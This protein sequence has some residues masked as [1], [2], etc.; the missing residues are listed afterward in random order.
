MN[1]SY[2]EQIKSGNTELLEKGNLHVISNIFAPDYIVYSG[3]KK[4]SG[5]EFIKRWT[6]QLR[7]A[8]PDVRIIKVEFHIQ[9]ENMIVWQRT[10]LG[11]HKSTIMG[12]RPSGQKI[13]WVEMVISRFTG[14]K[15]AEEWVVSELAGALLSKPPIQ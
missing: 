15:I 12:A 1:N 14:D 7:Y 5:H 13:K 10:L 6:R 8:I 2:Q 4:Y 11:T 9:A 3:D